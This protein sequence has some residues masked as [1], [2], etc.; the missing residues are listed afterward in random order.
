M[1]PDAVWAYIVDK[2]ISLLTSWP[3]VV[4]VILVP[5]L[6]PHRSRIGDLLDRGFEAGPSGFK[7]P[8][9]QQQ[10]DKPTTIE[11]ARLVEAQQLRPA[12]QGMKD[13]LSRAP[14]FQGLSTEAKFDR[15]VSQ[16][17][18]AVI[19]VRFE[20]LLQAIWRSQIDML[21]R[22]NAVGGRIPMD[23]ARASYEEGRQRSPAAYKEYSLE[24]W[25]QFLVNWQLI[26]IMN[27]T[28][29]IVLTE[30]GREFV[31]YLTDANVLEPS[32]G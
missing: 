26:Q 29:E 30:Q 19:A 7:V 21:R 1:Q 4:L 9:R 15:A 28:G 3:F 16:L 12:V 11:E 17:A 18:Y 31:R 8:P 32:V 20:R 2:A 27:D 23:L 5:L 13:T 6:W 14:I 24:A 25:L 10:V 22:T